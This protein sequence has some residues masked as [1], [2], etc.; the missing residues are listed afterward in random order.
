M[1]IGNR[2]CG[3]ILGRKKYLGQL[4]DTTGFSRVVFQLHSYQV[5][6][7]DIKREDFASKLILHAAEAGGVPGKCFV[8]V[9]VKLKNH[10]AEAGGVHR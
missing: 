10:A 1:Q 2:D 3:R 8:A 9:E 5:L 6:F 7:F 4:N